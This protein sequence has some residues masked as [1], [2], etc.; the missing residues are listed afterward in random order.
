MKRFGFFPVAL[1]LALL[2]ALLCGG[3][4]A[5]GL[6]SRSPVL[7]RI[8]KS[9]ELRVGMTGDYPPLSVVDRND[10]TIGLE[11]DLAAALAT[12]LGVK[13]VIVSKAFVDLIPAL[14]NGDV[15]V[16]MAGMTMTPERNMRVAFAGPYFLSGKAV[17]TR[18][19]TLARAKGPG[20]LDA[21]SVKL[22]TLEGTTSEG[23]V[24]NA[25]PHATLITTRTYEE[26]VTMVI[27]GAADAMIADYP[28]CV[29]AVLR[30][31]GAGLST[32]ISPFTFEPIGMALPA[33]DMLFV[34]LV[35]NY[36]KSLEGTGLLDQLR[37]KWF[38]DPSWLLGLP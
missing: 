22:V 10:R 27:G 17:L 6:G 25:M 14:E 33:D 9:G 5:V 34:N 38:A 24:Q 12:T 30:N 4:A 19:E 31:P 15:D 36:L 1:S 37:E 2:L 20:S 16:V 32:V 21:E 7:D 23:Y 3:C 11:P 13:L 35:N 28:I 26:A 29:V 18:S 8:Q